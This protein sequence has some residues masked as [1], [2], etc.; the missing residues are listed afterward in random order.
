M[1]IY[2]VILPN[3]SLLHRII[4][5][6]LYFISPTVALYKFTGN[7]PFYLKIRHFFGVY[8]TS[9]ILWVLTIEHVRTKYV[10]V[11]VLPGYIFLWRSEVMVGLISDQEITLQLLDLFLSLV[12]EK[13]FMSC[14]VDLWVVFDV[15][16]IHIFGLLPTWLI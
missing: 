8:L 9:D 3:I 2:K 10:L 15:H 11:K 1:Y 12:R 6:C 13:I 5:C 14:K 7:K 16:P 4:T